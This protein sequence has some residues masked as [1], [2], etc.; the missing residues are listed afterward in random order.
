VQGQKGFSWRQQF[1][2]K[3]PE[4]AKHEKG[5]SHGEKKEQANAHFGEK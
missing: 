1:V 2:K 3:E 4:T 5:D